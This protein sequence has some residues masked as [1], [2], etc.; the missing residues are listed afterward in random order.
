MDRQAGVG[1]QSARS[2]RW[3]R[4]HI[5]YYLLA[6]LNV[7]AIAFSLLLGQRVIRAFEVNSEQTMA[8]DRQFQVAR[9]ISDATMEAQAAVIDG[10]KTRKVETATGAFQGK[11]AEIR[12]ELSHDRQR[13]AEA[14]TEGTRKRMLLTL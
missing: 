10:L 1:R 7:S 5:F 8:L 3:P 2:E 13:L 6:F 14:M 11:L 9:T 12:S 4:L